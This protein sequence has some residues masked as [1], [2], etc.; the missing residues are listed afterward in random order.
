MKSSILQEDLL[1]DDDDDRLIL[2][3]SPG[4]GSQD[5]DLDDMD[6]DDELGTMASDGERVIYPWMKKIHVAGVGKSR[7]CEGKKKF[8]TPFC[9]LSLCCLIFVVPNIIPFLRIIAIQAG[10]ACLNKGEGKKYRFPQNYV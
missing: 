3:R 5:N 9:N 1:D 10:V 7:T 4:E 6:S 2:D 8:L